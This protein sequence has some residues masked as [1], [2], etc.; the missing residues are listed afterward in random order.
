V[1]KINY[2]RANLRKY[3]DFFRMITRSLH[4]G[5]SMRDYRLYCLDGAGKITSAEW[6]EADSDAEAVAAARA[7]CKAVTCE[8]WQRRRFVARIPRFTSRG[9]R[10]SSAGAGRAPSP[11]A[12]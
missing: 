3:L 6:L 12:R 4:L 9:E 1:P 7:L 8:V 11:P 10:A 2:D 5:G